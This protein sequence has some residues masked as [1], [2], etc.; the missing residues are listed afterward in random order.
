VPA[1]TGIAGGGSAAANGTT[2][3]N[4]N[5]SNTPALPPAGNGNNAQTSPAPGGSGATDPVSPPPND[6]ANGGNDGAGTEETPRTGHWEEVALPPVI[7]YRPLYG[8][9]CAEC[10][11]DISGH[12][13]EHLR[14]THHSGYYEGV[15]G[16][17][18]YEVPGGTTW[19]W[20][21]D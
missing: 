7:A 17:E 13:A 21:W 3:A 5:N 1:G 9:I 8:S 4:S 15:V 6:T 18:P 16:S 19:Q 20:V 14:A 11:A 12:A 10:R 2:T